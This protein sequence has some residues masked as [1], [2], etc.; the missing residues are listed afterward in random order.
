VLHEGALRQLVADLGQNQDGVVVK[1]NP[2]KL[3]TPG[4]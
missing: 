1:D 4:H 3:F 2:G